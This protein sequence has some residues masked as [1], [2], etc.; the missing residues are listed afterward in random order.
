MEQEYITLKFGPEQRFVLRIPVPQLADIS[1]LR[2]S[3]ASLLAEL[4]KKAQEMD[5]KQ[6]KFDWDNA[7]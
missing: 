4:D 2:D 7:A 3:V 1:E 5:P 6:L